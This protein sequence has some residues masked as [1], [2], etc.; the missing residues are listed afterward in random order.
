MTATSTRANI[1]VESLQSRWLPLARGLS[2]AEK[3][4][5]LALVYLVALTLAELMTVM[6][7]PQAG[8]LIHLILLFMIM[9][10][11]AATWQRPI[12]RFL[13]GLLFVPL[14]RVISLSLTPE[15]VSPGLLVSHH[16]HPP[17]RRHLS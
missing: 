13:I 7:A 5:G 11:A 10:H 1:V 16:Q 12:H 3:P 6:V 17:L 9:V 15:R 2:L 8:A 4:Y 14:I